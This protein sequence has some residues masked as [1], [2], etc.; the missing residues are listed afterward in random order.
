[1]TAITKK[2]VKLVEFAENLQSQGR[3]WFTKVEAMKALGVTAPAFHKATQRLIQQTKLTRI[4]NG[5]YVIVP[6]EYRK[7]K[8]LPATYYIDS[9]M[10]FMKQPYYVG[11]LSAAA[12]HGAAHQS[13]QELQIVTLR[14]IPPIEIAQ[15]RIRFITKKEVEKTPVQQVKT[16]T[17]YMQVSTPEATVLDLLR[18]VRLS[19]H[20]DNVTTAIVEMLDTINTPK[21]IQA[22]KLEKEFSYVQ[23]LGYLIDRFSNN[24]VAT[25]EL[26]QL[27]EKRRPGYIFLRPDQRKGIIEKNEK[28]NIFVNTEVELDI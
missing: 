23:R 8:G 18:Y 7:S 24:K 22:A 27:L 20:L 13:P 17:G 26:H 16:P 9:L 15:T 14:P 11:A 12:L 4:R 3:Y 1:M 5:F 25:K 6:A 19:G 2:H 21:L 28:W 10:K